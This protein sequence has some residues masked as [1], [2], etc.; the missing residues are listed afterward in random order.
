MGFMEN[1]IIMGPMVK[2]APLPRRYVR[3]G[4]CRPGGGGEYGS[5]LREM[6]NRQIVLIYEKNFVFGLGGAVR[7]HVGRSSGI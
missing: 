4:I 1:R 3:Q 7:V 5:V 2:E 6:R